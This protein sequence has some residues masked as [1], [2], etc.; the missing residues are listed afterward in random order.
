MTRS[1]AVAGLLAVLFFGLAP[2]GAWAHAG[3]QRSDPSAGTRLGATPAAVHLTLS[4]QPEASLSEI[5]V[6]ATNGTS[7]DAGPVQ[8]V[9][10]DPLSLSAPV[11]PLPRGVY[12]VNWRVV[13]AIDGH[14]TAGAYSFGV[15]VSPQPGLIAV[16]ASTSTPAVSRLEV[17]ARWILIGG[18]VALLGAA[19]A[20]V[21]RFGGG[22]ELMLGACAWGVSVVGLLLLAV[23]QRRNAGASFSELFD[24]PVGR[25]L[26][27][28]ALALAA[29]GGALLLAHRRS[30]RTRWLA[31]WGVGLATMAAMAFHVDAG[32]AAA[33][34][35]RSTVRIVEQ[36]A[37]F[38]AVGIWLG[39]LLALLLG[40]RG[41]PSSAKA[42]AV[43]RFSTI[44][45]FALVVV[46]L[47]GVL[48]SVNELSSWGELFSTGYGRAVL[49]K[50]ALLLAIAVFGALN[51]FRSVPAAAA[52]LRPLRQRAGGELGLTAVAL[53]AAAVLGSLAPPAASRAAAPPG[54]SASG[55]DFGTTT[56]VELTTASDQPGPNRF[57]AEVVDYDSKDPVEARRVS[58]RFTPLDDPGVA[59]TSLRLR[60]SSD[61]S[62]AGSG[63]NIAFEGRW[64]VTMLVERSGGDSV[65]IPLELVTRTPPQ[66][67]SIER[68]P[69][70]APHYQVAVPEA[71]I[72]QFSP[73]PERVGRSRLDVGF[74]DFL[75]GERR[76][77]QVVLT[78]AEGDGPTRQVPDRRLG[79]GRFVT[80]VELGAGRNT[81]TAVART[82]D[83]TRVRAAV[84]I[85]VPDD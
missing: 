10:G 77:E 76:I 7:F 41:A 39:G 79:P 23:V 84:D 64:G 12:T 45:A 19:A 9:S 27:W 81:L 60:A 5:N 8:A 49:A 43:R 37:H 2:A 65:E 28:R 57:V 78:A 15:L 25:A 24:T 34:A 66:S 26:G 44:A 71:G 29:A 54:L 42:A 31:L 83:G 67:V 68:I 1:S 32:H 63:A 75:G 38:S 35:S 16:E 17:L 50:V 36:W 56:R 58:L 33:G 47:T 69:G 51:R 48:R 72:V 21:A 74:F 20:G 4:E 82:V 52:N 18:L 55:A 13:S 11:R 3:L 80:T 59:A 46:V 62:Y 61:G 6:V 53:L 30:G 14:A 73:N 40:V 85:D 22:K 70:Q